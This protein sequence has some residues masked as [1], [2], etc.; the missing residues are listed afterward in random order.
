M[1]PL[2]I[3]GILLIVLGLAGLVSGGFS[4]T[5]DQET[6]EARPAGYHR[7]REKA[8]GGAHVGVGSG[9]RGGVV[10]LLAGTRRGPGPLDEDHPD[11][12][13]IAVGGREQGVI[14]AGRHAALAIVESIPPGFVS[15]LA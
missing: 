13:A 11:A 12:V 9:G 6:A 10:L 1:K 5:K 4:Y 15:A 14:D 8:R 2:T 3:V 7:D